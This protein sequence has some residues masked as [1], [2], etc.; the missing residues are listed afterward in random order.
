M[1]WDPPSLITNLGVP[2]LGNIVSS[3]ILIELLCSADLHGNASTH[4][5]T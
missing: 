2:N 5:V 3:N 1:K 4:L